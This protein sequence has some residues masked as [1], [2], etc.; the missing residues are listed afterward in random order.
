MQTEVLFIKEP[1][2][3]YDGGC[4]G[5]ALTVL[6]PF[7]LLSFKFKTV[8]LGIILSI[9]IV[10]ALV[11]WVPNTFRHL[12]AMSRWRKRTR[13]DKTRIELSDTHLISYSKQGLV[14]G[15]YLVTEIVD[16]VMFQGLD[17]KHH[18]YEERVIRFAGNQ[19]MSF[20]VSWTERL[21]RKRF[22][23]VLQRRTGKQFQFRS[24]NLRK[25]PN[26]AS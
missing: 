15:Q 24:N 6:T 11:F 22:V 2:P 1:R 23:R 16:L 8:M 21:N 17:E 13:E 14:E 12:T 20:F 9:F 5:C 10:W 26:S 4:S 3:F 19:E 25:P 18:P 7:L